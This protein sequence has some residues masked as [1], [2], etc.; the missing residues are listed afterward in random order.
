MDFN[1]R[2]YLFQQTEEHGEQEEGITL[3]EEEEVELEDE[4]D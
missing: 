1:Y 4:G 2:C 3:E